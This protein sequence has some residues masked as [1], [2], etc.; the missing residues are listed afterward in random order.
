MPFDTD[1][2]CN[3][4]PW[5]TQTLC[6]EV[7][8]WH[9][10]YQ[11]KGN[12]RQNLPIVKSSWSSHFH[13]KEP[14]RTTSSS[15]LFTTDPQASFSAPVQL[16]SFCLTGACRILSGVCAGTNLSRYAVLCMCSWGKESAFIRNCSLGTIFLLCSVLCTVG[17]SPSLCGAG[18]TWDCHN[19]STKWWLQIWKRSLW[20]FTALT[21]KKNCH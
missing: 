16:A 8:V 6:R 14:I 12:L 7:L 20:L 1:H 15:D 21:F 2:Q 10:S 19:L 11:N 3:S 18:N 17:F 9:I 5:V 13:P 4:P